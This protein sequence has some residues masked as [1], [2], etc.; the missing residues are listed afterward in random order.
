MGVCGE[1]KDLFSLF[2]GVNEEWEWKSPF[3]NQSQNSFQNSGNCQ[4]TELEHVANRTWVSVD[5]TAVW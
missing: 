5:R 1:G 2:T 3:L 4:L